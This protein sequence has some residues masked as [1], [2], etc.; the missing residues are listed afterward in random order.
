MKTLQHGD[1]GEEVKELQRRLKDLGF[2]AG[3][4]KGNFLHL[5]KEAVLAFERLHVDKQGTPLAADGIV[6]D[7]AWWALQHPDRASV[8][9]ILPTLQYG[10]R[11][12][13]VAI[14]QRILH[15]QG[16][17]K[18]A[19]GGNYL[20]LT[21]QAVTYFQQ[22]HLGP[23]GTFLP[24]DGKVDVATWWALRHP[25]G[26]PQRSFLPGKVPG[27]LTQLRNQQLE[28]AIAE[29]AAGVKEDPDGSN[30][31]DGVIKYNGLEG[32]PWCCYFWSWA[33]HQCHG[34]YTLG[35]KY[36]RVLSA[37]ERAKELNM[38]H[39]KGSYLPV[40]GDAF[41]M[42][43]RDNKGLLKGTGHIGLVLRVDAPGDQAR[44]INTVEG[45]SGNRVKVGHRK[46]DKADIV[47]FINSFPGDEQPVAWE[48]GLV[49][50]EST[51]TGG[52]T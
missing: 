10:D 12:E 16:F 7:D 20:T 32:Q 19:P 14:V 47:G 11:G 5:T 38:A 41:V 40:P 27:G 9:P 21:Q 1:R 52:T 8:E 26:R 4:V 33:S 45:N 37:W 49:K 25:V 13:H 44:A 31:G 28:I 42:L 15:Q 23:D 43:Y 3:E 46:L 18:G 29:H 24:V 36:G 17:F 48:R 2:F 39:D 50:A 30:W 35:A 51:A 34:R 22:T 6:D